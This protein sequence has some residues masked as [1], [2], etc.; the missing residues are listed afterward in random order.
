MS[1][2]KKQAKIQKKKNINKRKTNK[3]TRNQTLVN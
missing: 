1:N 2:K 3:Q